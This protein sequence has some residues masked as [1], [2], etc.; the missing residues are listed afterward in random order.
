[1]PDRAS[2]DDFLAQP[3][4]AVVGVSRDSKQFANVVYRHLRAGGRTLYPVNAMADGAPLEGDQ[5]YPSIA[6]LPDPVDGVLIMVPA[7]AAVDVARDA[8]ARG[9]GRVWLHRGVGR[10]AVSEEAVRACRDAGVRVVDGACPLMFADPVHG[11][12]RLHRALSGHRIA[13]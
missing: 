8:V 10:G 4:V 13:A 11:V 2:I 3:H 1:M 7:D 5:S 6:A 9:V 12:H